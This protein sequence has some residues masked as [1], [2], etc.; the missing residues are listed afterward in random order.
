MRR[1]AVATAHALFALLLGAANAL[2]QPPQYTVQDLGTST[3]SLSITVTG[4]NRNGVVVGYTS[5][6][7]GP[8]L[9]FRTQPNAAINLPADYIGTLGGSGT[10]GTVPCSSWAT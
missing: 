7:G 9:A 4:M 5:S 10:C 6:S 1:H 8:T 2:A 3:S